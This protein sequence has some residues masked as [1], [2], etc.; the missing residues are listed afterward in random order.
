MVRHAEVLFGDF[1]VNAAQKQEPAFQGSWLQSWEEPEARNNSTVISL[2]QRD[3][4]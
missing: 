3:E 4:T 2:L 1:H